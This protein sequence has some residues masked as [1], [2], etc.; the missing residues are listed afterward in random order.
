MMKRSNIALVALAALLAAGAFFAVSSLLKGEEKG[1]P[2]APGVTATIKIELW[3]PQ[4][5]IRQR[6]NLACRNNKPLG[7]TRGF[8]LDIP[9]QAERACKEVLQ[10]ASGDYSCRSLSSQYT[11]L[12]KGEIEGVVNGKKLK[13]VFEQSTNPDCLKYDRYWRQFQEVWSIQ[14]KPSPEAAIKAREQLRKSRERNRE[15]TRKLN[16]DRRKAEQQARQY[17]KQNQQFIAPK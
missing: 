9:S 1:T 11:S 17:D 7:A 3:H 14:D 10:L 5:T 16:E 12:G 6:M 13:A 4:K 8:N 15:L 2:D